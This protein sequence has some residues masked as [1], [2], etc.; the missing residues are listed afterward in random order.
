MSSD[1]V[2]E[3]SGLVHQLVLHEGIDEL[4]DLVGSTVHAAIGRGAPVIVAG[5]DEAMSAVRQRF[6]DTV[7][8]LSVGDGARRPVAEF[9]EVQAVLERDASRRA[10]FLTQPPVRT[11][12]WADLRRMEAAINLLLG[13][14]P[15]DYLCAYERRGLSTAMVEE[16]LAAHPGHSGPQRDDD[17]LVDPFLA[18]LLEG[19]FDCPSD[20]LEATVPDV[21]LVD[22]VAG[23]A[24]RSIVEACA[25]LG[26]VFDL[27]AM[28]LAASEIVENA[29]KYGRAPVTF[30]VWAAPHRLV[31]SVNDS[32]PGPSDMFHGLWRRNERGAA[33]GL[34]VWIAH[35]VVDVRQRR[36]AD[37]YTVLLSLDAG[38]IPSR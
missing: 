8:S 11:G 9:A 13:G 5:T 20:L 35:Q 36:D 22:P 38:P 28:V 29:R 26:D 30:R 33:G 12:S 25:G 23:E 1:R 21:V 31:V 27:D 17:L 6:G 24:R 37:G 3:S 16:L 14:R 34:G 19:W 10:C 2:I 32:G 15:V 18:S 7:L 4:L